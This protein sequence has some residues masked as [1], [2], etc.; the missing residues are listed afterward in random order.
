MNDKLAAAVPQNMLQE[1]SLRAAHGESVCPGRIPPTT[2][3]RA[4]RTCSGLVAN[5]LSVCRLHRLG[6][7][8]QTKNQKKKKQNSTTNKSNSLVTRTT[9][10][11]TSS[12]RSFVPVTKVEKRQRQQMESP[13]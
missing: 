2:P 7:E 10:P 5:L 4:T 3:Q 1:P 9:N 11:A 6:K 13:G 12:P 8:K